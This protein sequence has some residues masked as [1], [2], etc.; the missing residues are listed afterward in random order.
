MRAKH[1]CCESTT[2]IGDVPGDVTFLGARGILRTTISP[3]PA[4]PPSAARMQRALARAPLAAARPSAPR[5]RPAA[6][7]AHAAAHAITFQTPSGACETVPC[8]A[9]STLLSAA[10]DA[11]VALRHLCGVGA[12]STCAGRILKGEVAQPDQCALSDAQVAEGF[13][14]MCMSYPR[15]DV[16]I[17]TEQE[18]NAWTAVSMWPGH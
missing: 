7:A 18:E 17:L 5:P 16:T 9:S 10:Q 2:R 6:V 1:P 13:A 8:D 4:N 15:S 3:K 12:C 11:G 14:L